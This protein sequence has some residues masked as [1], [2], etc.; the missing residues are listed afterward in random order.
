MSTTHDIILVNEMDEQVGTMEKM[1]AHEKGILHRAFSVFI[2][3][4]SNNILL[5]QRAYG[6]YHSSG[7][8]TNACCSHPKP[9]ESIEAA[10]HR[11]LQE[12]L[13][14]DTKLEKAFTFT[15]KAHFDNGLTEY[16]YDH[17]FIGH[18][19]DPI[20]FNEQEVNAI[21]YIPL[22]LLKLELD[23]NPDHFTEWFKIAMPQLDMW[24]SSQA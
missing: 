3:D 17:V 6:K 9:G 5:Q 2:F 18:Y 12:E 15:Y 24:L 10:A 21:K 13:G 11:R 16:E 22:D 1:E 4:S 8:W 20:Q 7:L 19:E 14:F 23:E